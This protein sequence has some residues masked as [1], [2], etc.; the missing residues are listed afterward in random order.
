MTNRARHQPDHDSRVRAG[1]APLDVYFSRVVHACAA[2]VGSP[3]Q[4]ATAAEVD[5]WFEDAGY[6]LDRPPVAPAG[7]MRSADRSYPSLGIP[8]HARLDARGEPRRRD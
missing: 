2:M 3:T 1:L 7:S 5:S 8:Q 6:C 4:R